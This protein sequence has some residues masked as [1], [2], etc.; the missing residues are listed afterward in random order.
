MPPLPSWLAQVAAV[1]SAIA[2]VVGE[3]RGSIELAALVFCLAYRD[4]KDAQAAG[5]PVTFFY[6]LVNV[7][8]LRK[9]GALD[10][11]MRAR[12]EHLEAQLQAV[13]A[14]LQLGQAPPQPGSQPG[15][16]PPLPSRE[17]PGPAPNPVPM[18]GDPR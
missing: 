4:W 6:A 18:T 14:R 11:E 5:K 9:A 13:L 17:D 10:V 2:G 12:L 16:R 1:L 8:L 15:E 7:I 3:Y